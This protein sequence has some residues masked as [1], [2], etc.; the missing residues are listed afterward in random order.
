M[1]IIFLGFLLS[2]TSL[3]ILD[4]FK[5]SIREK[6]FSFGAHIHLT[7]YD[8]DKSYEESPFIIQ[9]STLDSI[10]AI[11]TVQHVQGVSHKP[12]LLKSDTE[13]QGVILKGVGPDFDIGRFKNNIVAGSFIKFNDTTYSK[14][15]IVSEKIAAK[16]KIKI[17]DS[18]L[19][20][21]VQNPPRFRKVE[22]CGIYQTGL[23]ELDELFI[24][25]DIQLNRVLSGWSPKQIGGMEIYVSDFNMLDSTA[26]L[27]YKKMDYDMQIQLIT[28]KY[29][30]IFDWLDLLNRNVTI[31]LVLIMGVSIFV[32]VATLIVMI[33]E[34]T[35]MVGLLKAFGTT[36]T[37]V[38]KIFLWNGF[39][40]ILTGMTSG[41]IVAL[42]LCALQYYTGIV[43]LDAENYF[44]NSVPIEFPWVAIILVNTAGL[45]ILSLVL[46]APIYFISRVSPVKSIK[47]N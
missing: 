4:G 36:N 46:W 2:V 37:E 45:A 9:H 7:K 30:Q 24:I 5:T 47:F 26:S 40:I 31:F 39:K 29:L 14:Q 23:E 28:D 20:Y 21:F 22:I 41:N 1:I 16:L 27:V 11:P 32:I 15:I 43:P 10:K 25:G 17:G 35:P 44:M 42:A 8:L 12:C 34:R 3:C 19:L 6:I 18:L 33:M 13:I 38:S